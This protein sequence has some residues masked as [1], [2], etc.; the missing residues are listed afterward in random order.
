MCG[1]AGI[2]NFNTS[3]HVREQDI[4]TMMEKMKHRGPDDQGTYIAENLGFGFVRLSILDLSIAGH[5]P[6]FSED[7]RYMIIFNGEVYNYIEIR[8]ELKDKYHFKTG[9]DTEVILTAYQEWGTDC[10]DRFNGMFAFVI[11]DTQTKEVFGGRLNAMIGIW[12]G[13]QL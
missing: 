11:L 12:V 5:Q 7:K 6:M 1:I 13:L 4:L 2:V 8:E 3:D 9:T 10:L